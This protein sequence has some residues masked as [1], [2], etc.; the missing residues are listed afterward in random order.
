MINV[1]RPAINVQRRMIN[2]QNRVI[3]VQRRV[4]KL[5]ECENIEQ[6]ARFA[7]SVSIPSGP[8]THPAAQ[9]CKTL[10]KPSNVVLKSAAFTH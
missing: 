4:I 6:S 3:N 1:Q 10:A 7:G 2:V 9:A 5:Q 8:D